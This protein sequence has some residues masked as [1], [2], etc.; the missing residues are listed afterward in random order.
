MTQT[1]ASFIPDPGELVGTF[2]RFGSFGPAYEIIGVG[3]EEPLGDRWMKVRVVE[4]GEVLDY[5]FSD[6]LDDPKER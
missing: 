4:S 6:I 2:R 5:K 3:A 1:A